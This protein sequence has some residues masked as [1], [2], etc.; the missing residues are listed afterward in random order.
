MIL[1]VHKNTNFATYN[2]IKSLI[3]RPNDEQKIDI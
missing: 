3:K 2:P 1:K